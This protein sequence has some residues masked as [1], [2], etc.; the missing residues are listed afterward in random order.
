MEKK[1]LKVGISRDRSCSC[2][3]C[4][5]RV[6]ETEENK[7]VIAKEMYDITLGSSRHVSVVRLCDECLNE[8]ADILWQFLER[9]N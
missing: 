6:S 2:N 1:V 9:M 8:F 4:Y 3:A 5:K 7:S